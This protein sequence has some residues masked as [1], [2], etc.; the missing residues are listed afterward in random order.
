M[1]ELFS[2]FRMSQWWST[3]FRYVRIDR[4]Y[5]DLEGFNNLLSERHPL[6]GHG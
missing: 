5:L 2:N 6:V 4:G 3:F 1:K